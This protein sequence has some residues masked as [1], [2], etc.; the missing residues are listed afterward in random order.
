MV[1]VVCGT[2]AML[3]H[4]EW[5]SNIYVGVFINIEIHVYLVGA[6]WSMATTM[7]CGVVLLDIQFE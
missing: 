3:T 7:G 5:N 6:M 1:V 4:I 2:I